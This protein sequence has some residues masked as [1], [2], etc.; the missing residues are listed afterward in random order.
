MPAARSA[1]RRA[2]LFLGANVIAK[3]LD[4]SVTRMRY[5]GGVRLPFGGADQSLKENDPPLEIRLVAFC[6]VGLRGFLAPV[7]F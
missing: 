4:Q 7:M 6:R 3:G 2:F 1:G 5:E